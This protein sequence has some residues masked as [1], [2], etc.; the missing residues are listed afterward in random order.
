MNLSELEEIDREGA[1]M[2]AKRQGV[3]S[4]TAPWHL[5]TQGV[6]EADTS[7]SGRRTSLSILKP[8]THPA[9]ASLEHPIN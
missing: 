8:Q 2:L 7:R 4:A 3:E 5:M 1:K 6:L 9:S